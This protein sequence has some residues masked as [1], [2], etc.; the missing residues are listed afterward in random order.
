L[1]LATP[2]SNIAYQIHPGVAKDHQRIK[3]SGHTSDGSA[4]VELQLVKDGETLAALDRADRIEMWWTL[5]PGEHNFWLEGRAVSEDE[6]VRTQA[7]LVIVEAFEKEV[8]RSSP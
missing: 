4:W 1:I 8:A 6:V 2:A 3:I 5:T 7:A